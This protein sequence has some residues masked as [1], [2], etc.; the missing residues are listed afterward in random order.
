[1]QCRLCGHEKTHKH[2]KSE[3]GQQRYY[4][5][6]CGKTYTESF[7][8]AYYRRQVSAAEINTILQSHAEGSSLRGISRITGRAYGTV[9]SVIRGASQKAQMIHNE[10]I[11]HVETEAVIADEMWSFVKKNKKTVCQKSK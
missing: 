3:Q 7:D 1:M 8:T 6:H 4:C 5:P 9:V 11:K 10:D 2:G